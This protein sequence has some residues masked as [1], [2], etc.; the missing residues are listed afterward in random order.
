MIPPLLS[1]F[2]LTALESVVEEI[3]SCLGQVLYFVGTRGSS[4]EG[5]LDNVPRCVWGV[6]GFSAC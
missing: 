5:H 6:A 4:L 1:L 3:R 2:L